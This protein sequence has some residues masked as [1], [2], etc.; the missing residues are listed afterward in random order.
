MEQIYKVGDN[1]FFTTFV[2]MFYKFFSRIIL[3]FWS[4]L[5]VNR[6][7]SGNFNSAKSVLLLE[8]KTSR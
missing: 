5:K 4:L 8:N 6:K 2:T 7:T 1:S 3:I